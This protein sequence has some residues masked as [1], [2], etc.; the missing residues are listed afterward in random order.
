LDPY[1]KYGLLV[2]FTLLWGVLS[3]YG[4]K[5]EWAWLIDPPEALMF[6]YSQAFVKVCFGKE[7]TK[8][9]TIVTGWITI[10]IAI[11][12]VVFL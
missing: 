6:V 9:Y 3:V 8:S 7:S 2:P 10:A 12:E 1:L 11:W 5:R 4:G